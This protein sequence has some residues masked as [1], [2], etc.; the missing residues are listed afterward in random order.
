MKL[1]KLLSRGVSIT[2]SAERVSK[3]CGFPFSMCLCWRFTPVLCCCFYAQMGYCRYDGGIQFGFIFI[4]RKRNRRRARYF[5]CNTGR[6]IRPCVRCKRVRQND[7]NKAYKRTYTA[8]FFR[9]PFGK[10]PRCRQGNV[11]HTHSGY[12]G[13]GRI[14]VP[15]SAHAVF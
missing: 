8:F 9:Q 5:V 7:N 15:K 3:P 12:I 4:Y 13:Y 10:R 14:G 11:R 1:H 6:T 2:C